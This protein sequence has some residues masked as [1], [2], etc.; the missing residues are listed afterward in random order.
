MFTIIEKK[1]SLKGLKVAIIGDIY[2]SRVAR[3]NIWGMTKLGAEVS[4]AG[5]STLMPPEL[6]KTGVKVFTT[7]QEALIDADV[8]MGLRIQKERQKSGLFPSLREYSR[9]FG[10]DDALILHPGPVN[11]GVELPS[12]VIDSERSFINEQ[13]TNGV[14]VR[15]ALLYLLTRRDS[16]ES[17]N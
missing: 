15:M 3:S 4:V 12:S 10:L 13:V 17:V 5:P 2:H 7:V 14:A 1:G 8:V 9:F 11:R 16:G 6:D